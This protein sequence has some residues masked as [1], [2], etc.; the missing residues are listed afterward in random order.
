MT[1]RRL[2]LL[3]LVLV[4]IALWLPPAE[5]RVRIGVT[6]RFR[7]V[8]NTSLQGP[9]GERLYLARRLVEKHFLLPYSIEDGGYVLG[10]SGDSRHYYPMPEGETLKALQRAGRLP[11]PLPPY[12]MEFLDLLFG[13]ALWVLIAGFGLYGAVRYARSRRRAEGVAGQVAAIE[14]EPP[15]AP[16]R[17]AQADLSLPMKLL[18]SRLKMLRMLAIAAAFVAIGVLMR[19]KE[20]VLGVLVSTFFGVGTVVLLTQLSRKAAYL[21]LSQDGFTFS[22]LFKT[23]RFAW[24]DVAGFRVVAMR[25]H[26]MVGW[27][28]TPGYAGQASGRRL[29]SRLVGVEGALPDTYG[30]RA[31][32]LAELM[33]ELKARAARGSRTS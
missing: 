9:K 17:Y 24:S 20:P 31:E 21:E 10:I 11:D 22:T 6:E 25:G 29:A 16:T 5:A 27:D 7:H 13:H 14:G 4:P 30:R 15:P 23:R 33:N 32:D 18:P 8:A 3:F 28:F 2:A 1:V 12:Q 19:E 26:R